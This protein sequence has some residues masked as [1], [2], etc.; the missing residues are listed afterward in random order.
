MQNSWRGG[1]AP[2]LRVCKEDRGTH[3]LHDRWCTYCAPAAG[4]GLAGNNQAGLPS[5]VRLRAW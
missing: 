2:S 5:P 1:E 3:L 4:A